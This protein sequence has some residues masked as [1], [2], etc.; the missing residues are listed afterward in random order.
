MTTSNAPAKVEEAPDLE[1]VLGTSDSQ[2]G[3]V[4][5]TREAA[6]KVSAL[7]SREDRTDLMLRVAVQ[8]GGCSGLVYQ[9]YFDERVLDGDHVTNFE[10][11]ALV[12]D[13]MSAPYLGGATVGY[14]D[15]I[16]NQGFTIKN[17][18][19]ESSCACGDSFS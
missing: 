19:A 17:P 18:N 2:P 6:E 8:P 13:K 9:L 16:A 7:L 5:L 4:G 10:H 3:P 15:T 11:A 12:V 1:V 14:S